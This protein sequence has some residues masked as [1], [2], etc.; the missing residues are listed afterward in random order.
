MFWLISEWQ[1]P[2]SEQICVASETTDNGAFVFVVL[3]LY[4]SVHSAPAFLST[5]AEVRNTAR[6]EST[7][8]RRARAACGLRARPHSCNSRATRAYMRARWSH[9]RAPLPAVG[10]PR[11]CSLFRR[12]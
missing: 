4:Y 10:S 7:C 12:G 2:S 8:G 1:A 6:G 3:T 11:A 5:L 9:A